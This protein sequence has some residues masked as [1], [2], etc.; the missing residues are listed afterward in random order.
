MKRIIHHP[1]KAAPAVIAAALLAGCQ[2]GIEPVV[3]AGTDAYAAIAVD[4]AETEMAAARYGLRGGDVVSVAV[5]QEPELS[6]DGIALDAAGNINLPLLGEIRAGGLTTGELARLIERSYAAQY[7][8]DPRV[9]V[10]LDESVRDMV[11]V[12]GEVELPGMYEYRDGLTLLSSLAL[13]R[14]PTEVARLDQVVIFRDVGG[15]RM[16]GVFNV[17]AIREGRMPDPAMRPGDVV[18]VGYSAVQGRY[19]DFLRAAPILGIFTR[20]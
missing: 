18:V 8:R 3:P 9:A 12:E 17:E 10:Y 5:F 16:G 6:R 1:G 13:A 19:R 20:F 7:L 11:S 15:E 14:S 4:P 2:S